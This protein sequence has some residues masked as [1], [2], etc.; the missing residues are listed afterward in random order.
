MTLHVLAKTIS[1]AGTPEV[2]VKRFR[3]AQSI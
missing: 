1:K 3:E 2:M